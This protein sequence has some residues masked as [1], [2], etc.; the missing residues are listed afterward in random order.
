VDLGGADEATELVRSAGQPSTARHRLS[1]LSARAIVAEAAGDLDVAS[2]LYRGAAVGWGEY[3]FGLECARVS[4]G[5]GRCLL[6]LGRRHEA[7]Q[8]LE[9]ARRLLRPL[10]ARP[11][12]AEVDALLAGT[13]WMGGSAP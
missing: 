3:R 7:V 5:A 4:L 6:A 11:L 10:G 9:E 1:L 13:A 12:L 2:D 8:L